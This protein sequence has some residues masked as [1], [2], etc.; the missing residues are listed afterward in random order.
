[1]KLRNVGRVAVEARQLA[2]F[3]QFNQACIAQL[4]RA[5]DQPPSPTVWNRHINAALRKA[6]RLEQSEGSTAV[7]V[8][9][10]AKFLSGWTV[11]DYL[12]EGMLQRRFIY[13]LTAQTGHGKTAIALRIAKAIDSILPSFL[14]GHQVDCGR[15]G[16]LVGENPDDVRAR[17]IGENAIAGPTAG[18]ILFVPG[19]FDTDSLLKKAKTL[20]PLDLLIVDTSAAYFLGAEENS[21]VEYGNHAR[22]LRRLIDL[23]G[24]PCVLVLCHPTKY[25]SEP[26]QLL[27]R[28]G[29]AFLAEIDGNLTAFKEESN[30][31]VL[32]HHPDKLRGP[33]FQ[34]ITF[35]LET[36]T[37][38]QLVDSKGR[39]L[40]TV[41]A[42]ALT[43][44]E[45]AA[46]V[47]Q[48]RTD[49]D[50]LMAVM[51][52]AQAK[53]KT[54]SIAE[55]AVAVGWTLANG[56]GNRSKVQRALKRLERDKLVKN[57]RG[58]WKLAK[59]ENQ[60]KAETGAKTKT[61]TKAKTGA[62]QAGAETKPGGGVKGGTEAGTK[63]AGIE[64]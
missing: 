28:G 8:Q 57:E 60:A 16:Y 48:A 52:E 12:I 15:V 6:V 39:L 56:E 2:D 24:G 34:P 47:E 64:D 11:P 32:H 22:K 55:M 61:G 9:N 18:N 42:V 41:R 25:A 13:S 49:E 36:I 63:Q 30:L 62:K 40:P 35:R 21:N 29:G 20:G 54:M 59:S 46:E 45:E 14:G 7:V 10:E 38:S 43:E 58:K 53:A 37:C 33:G 3:R 44:T 23:P 19:V 31:V 17:V 1:V 50:A 5:F 4:W 26:S 51:A 27:P